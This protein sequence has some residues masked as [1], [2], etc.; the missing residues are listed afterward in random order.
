MFVVA[1]L[2][3]FEHFLT[4]VCLKFLPLNRVLPNTMP[5]VCTFS[6]TR[7]L[8]VRLI[9]TEKVRNYEK[10]VFITNML[11]NGW[12]GDA[13]PKPPGSAPARTD[14]NVS[15][16]YSKQPVWLQ[17]DVRQILS[18]LFWNNSMYCT[19]TV[20]TLYFK[21]KGSVSKGGVDPPGCA[22]GWVAMHIIF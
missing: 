5:F 14:N 20:W 12:W 6:I 18:Q 21:N 4:K 16:H 7:A 11:Q 1:I 15:Y 13:S 3:L 9:I 19:C 22:T 10:I 2:V 8:G 17:Y